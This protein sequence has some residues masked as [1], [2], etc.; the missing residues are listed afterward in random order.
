M[1]ILYYQNHS[2]EQ[3]L[4][5]RIRKLEIKIDRIRWIVDDDAYAASFQTMGQYRAA[6]LKILVRD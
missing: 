3:I 1:S 5:D 4:L 2:K 6:L